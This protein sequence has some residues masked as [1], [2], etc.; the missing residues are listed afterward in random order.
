M[1]NNAP[2]SSEEQPE[3]ISSPQP[4]PESEEAQPPNPRGEA[5]VV[6]RGP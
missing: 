5:E 2:Q 6:A 3:E 1:Q 4:A